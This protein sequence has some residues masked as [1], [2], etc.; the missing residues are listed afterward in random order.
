MCTWLSGAVL[1]V[2]RGS[3]GQ[4]ETIWAAAV[5]AP[6]FI[7]CDRTPY[8]DR[9]EG[10]R[11]TPLDWSKPM[12]QQINAGHWLETSW[13]HF[14]D[15]GS[16]YESISS[17]AWQTSSSFLFRMSPST[18]VWR[19]AVGLANWERTW[20]L[21][22]LSLYV[23]MSCYVQ[24]QHPYY[25]A[26]PWPEAGCALYMA[27]ADDSIWGQ[28]SSICSL[29]SL[30]IYLFNLYQFIHLVFVGITFRPYNL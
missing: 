25:F 11:K 30:F 15:F 24:F 2:V 23:A 21:A 1:S 13:N 20:F 22:L 28:R 10:Y 3:T 8:E 14:Q 7:S 4:S 16:K 19:S 26:G 6:S 27:L 12:Y 18:D 9:L 29:S 5:K 17:K